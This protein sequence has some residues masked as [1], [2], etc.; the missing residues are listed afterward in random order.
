LVEYAPSSQAETITSRLS[1]ARSGRSASTAS[2][3]AVPRSSG[4]T[5]G[6]DPANA[7]TTGAT[8]PSGPRA[9]QVQN[10]P[11]TDSTELGGVGRLSGANSLAAWP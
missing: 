7:L 2:R 9:V 1:T 10:R 5:A 8:S 6:A 11:G 4:A 3:Y